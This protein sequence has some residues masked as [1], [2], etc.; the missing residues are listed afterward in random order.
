MQ[1]PSS[2]GRSG[3]TWY[4]D[5]GHSVTAKSPENGRRTL[6]PSWHAGSLCI[7]P[8]SPWF[9]LLPMVIDPPRH[10]AV[11]PRQDRRTDPS[12]CTDC[13]SLSAP[14][15]T[16]LT[17]R[18]GRSLAPINARY[19]LEPVNCRLSSR[20]EIGPSSS[21]NLCPSRIADPLSTAEPYR[22]CWVSPPTIVC[23]NHW[24]E[25]KAKERW[26][27]GQVVKRLRE[28]PSSSSPPRPHRQVM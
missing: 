16:A 6:Q 12:S 20:R 4:P 8:R 11:V 17:A 15:S 13:V 24:P 10:H 18:S 3:C 2:F 5:D 23:D 9:A 26:L 1:A 28:R 14:S 25:V 7:V 19:L 21:P 22:D 27:R